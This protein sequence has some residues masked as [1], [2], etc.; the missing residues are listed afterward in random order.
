MS[1][2]KGHTPFCHAS[3]LAGNRSVGLGSVV[4]SDRFG[5]P[6]LMN[7]LRDNQKYQIRVLGMYVGRRWGCVIRRVLAP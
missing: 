3:S 7:L 5:H 2:T 4:E 6:K 1:L